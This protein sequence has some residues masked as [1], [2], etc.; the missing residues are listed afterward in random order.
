[1]CWLACPRCLEKWN[2]KARGFARFKASAA[3][4]FRSRRDFGRIAPLAA[5]RTERASPHRRCIP[6]PDRFPSVSVPSSSRKRDTVSLADAF[7]SDHGQVPRRR[8]EPGAK[9]VSES[10]SGPQATLFEVSPG[11]EDGGASRLLSISRGRLRTSGEPG[12]RKA[13]QAQTSSRVILLGKYLRFPLTKRSRS[14]TFNARAGEVSISLPDLNCY[15]GK[16]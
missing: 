14:F 9:I 1:M 10:P 16:Y 5:N 8:T 12:S 11:R 6:R 15:V 13:P 4:E 2:L 7:P 3:G